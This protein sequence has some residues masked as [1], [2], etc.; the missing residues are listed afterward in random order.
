[1]CFD[2]DLQNIFMIGQFLKILINIVYVIMIYF[3]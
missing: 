3:N 2:E 1:M